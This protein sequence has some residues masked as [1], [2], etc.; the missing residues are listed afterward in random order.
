MYK[1]VAFVSVVVTVVAIRNRI[2]SESSCLPYFAV[3]ARDQVLKSH[4][5]CER[6]VCLAYS[7]RLLVVLVRVLT[8]HAT[9]PRAVELHQ[10]QLNFA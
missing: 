10:F 7:V 8:T 1:S 9:C 5:S 3:V 4:V 2:R 6:N